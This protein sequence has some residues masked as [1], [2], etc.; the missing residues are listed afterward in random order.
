MSFFTVEV[1]IGIEEVYNHGT[2]NV[3]PNPA[4]DKI[5]IDLGTS[6]LANKIV[7]VDP[8]GKVVFEDVPNSNKFD[9]NVEQYA[10]GTYLMNIYFGEEV[11]V[12]RI[13]IIR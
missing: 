5:T 9:V 2:L 1:T 7:M 4:T 8:A 10:E 11:V 3:Y 12:K 6:T 13:V